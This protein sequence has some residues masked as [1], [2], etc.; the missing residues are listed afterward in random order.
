ML[1]LLPSSFA[2]SPSLGLE[3][4]LL[5][6]RT[7]LLLTL[8]VSHA[9]FLFNPFLTRSRKQGVN[10]KILFHEIDGDPKRGVLS[11]GGVAAGPALR[12]ARPGLHSGSGLRGGAPVSGS[13]FQNTTEHHE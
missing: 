6:L 13:Y 11:A 1:F 3:M 2:L 7:S 8:A 9:V 12:P 5:E 4:F 10:G